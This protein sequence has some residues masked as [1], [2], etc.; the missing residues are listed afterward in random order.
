MKPEFLTTLQRTVA[1]R[2]APLAISSPL[3]LAARQ[4]ILHGA[5]PVDVLLRLAEAQASALGDARRSLQASQERQVWPARCPGCGS[6][7]EAKR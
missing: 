4:H 7:W 6:T 5:D 3:A 2:L 1:G